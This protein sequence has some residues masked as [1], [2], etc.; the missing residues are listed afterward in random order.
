VVGWV[1]F[2]SAKVDAQIAGLRTAPGGARLVGMRHQL[3]YEADRSWITREAVRSGLAVLAEHD[4]CFDIVITADQLPAV[5]ETVAAVPQLRFV[6]DHAGKPAIASHDLTS[7]QADIA[8]LAELPNVA[9]KLSGLVTEADPT[10]WRQADLDP[11]IDRVLECF[12]P[13]RVMAGSDWPVCLVAADYP[14]VQATLAPA[15]GGL[16]PSERADV[17]GGTAERWYLGGAR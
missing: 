10:A 4:L 15:V 8:R 11:V 9:C 13:A 17:L 3:Q 7:W 2:L 6:L 5:T 1:D 14:S 16:S 12:G